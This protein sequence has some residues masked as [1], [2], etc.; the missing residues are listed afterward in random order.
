MRER[1]V[2]FLVLG[3]TKCVDI[4]RNTGGVDGFLDLTDAETIKRG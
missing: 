1:K 3:R 2:E 4:R